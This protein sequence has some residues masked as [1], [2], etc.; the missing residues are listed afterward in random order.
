MTEDTRDS[1]GKRVPEGTAWKVSTRGAKT[2]NVSVTVG[3][4]V[5]KS[6]TVRVV[7][8]L[9]VVS[10]VEEREMEIVDPVCVLVGV[11]ESEAERVLLLVWETVIVGLPVKVSV[12]VCDLVRV[13][14][15]VVVAAGEDVRV[16]E[17]VR[18]CVTVSLAV[19]D[20]LPV[21]VCVAVRVPLGVCVQLSELVGV[22]VSERVGELDLDRVWENV[23]ETVSLYDHVSLG[24]GEKVGVSVMVQGQGLGS[25]RI[26]RC[27]AMY[28][29]V[30]VWLVPNNITR[31]V[32]SRMMGGRLFRT[33]DEL[34]YTSRERGE[35]RIWMIT[36]WFGRWTSEGYFLY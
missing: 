25:V 2:V 14:V 1:W 20:S 33:A 19:M 6:D 30:A 18:V 4:A 24:V 36:V 10:R 27:E 15:F 11:L 16:L 17:K 13:K 31:A 29:L 21:G 5:G 7:D 8:L 12:F 23:G 32:T 34:S 26:A 9:T 3:V 22:A 28:E 35:G